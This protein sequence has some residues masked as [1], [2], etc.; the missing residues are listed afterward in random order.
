ME[1]SLKDVLDLALN[2][3]ARAAHDKRSAYRTPVLSTADDQHRPQSRIVI[4]RQVSREPLTLWLYTDARSPKV[5][6]IDANPHVELLFWDKAASQQ[7]RLA[8]RAM[9]VTAGAQIEALK[10][11]LPDNVNGDY[12]RNAP[13]GSV[14]TDPNTALALEANEPL[15]F[16]RLTVIADTLDFLELSRNGHRRAG[17]SYGAGTWTGTW[18]VP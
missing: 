18:R 8:G 14:A 5:E 1:Q 9:V 7:L 3:V 6:Q 16:A 2:K 10:E 17:F 15:H 12:A 4:L 11:G 13:P